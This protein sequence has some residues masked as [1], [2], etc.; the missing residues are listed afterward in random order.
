[1]PKQAFPAAGGALPAYRPTI[2]LALT[3]G[4]RTSLATTI[5]NLID[6]LDTT[7]ADPDLEPD[8]DDEVYTEDDMLTGETPQ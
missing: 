2:F 1:M 7:D 5:E 3:P 8:Q 6:L 4:L